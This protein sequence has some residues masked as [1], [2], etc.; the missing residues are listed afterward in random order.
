M[1]GRLGPRSPASLHVGAAAA[2]EGPPPVPRDSLRPVPARPPFWRNGALL[3]ERRGAR[4]AAYIGRA[5]ANPR[6]ARQR[7]MP[8]P[9]GASPP[10]VPC[11]AGDAP[12]PGSLRLCWRPAGRTARGASRG[13]LRP[14]LRPR[15][16]TAACS[17]ADSRATGPFHLPCGFTPERASRPQAS[18][19]GGW[20]CCSTEPPAGPH[21][22]PPRPQSSG[23][24]TSLKPGF[25]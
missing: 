8:L 10:R 3:G 24:P 15:D 19:T 22:T 13:W 6:A 12:R 20:G 2:V 7:D 5:A 16:R 21:L 23:L 14:A 9:G 11:A 25:T 18:G 17:P 4:P 1:R